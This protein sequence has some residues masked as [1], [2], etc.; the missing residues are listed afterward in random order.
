[1]F[2][3]VF[4]MS[5]PSISVGVVCAYETLHTGGF[6]FAVYQKMK[7]MQ[8]ASRAAHLL[9]ECEGTKMFPFFT[10]FIFCFHYFLFFYFVLFCA[11]IL[12]VVLFLYRSV[13]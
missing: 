11:E 8:L 6:D 10:I 7:D 5:D 1:M 12:I 13:F 4:V 3:F 2:N 9:N